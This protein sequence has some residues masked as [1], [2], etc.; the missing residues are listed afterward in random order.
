[1]NIEAVN[2]VDIVV[3]IFG[4]IICLIS[5]FI[6]FRIIGLLKYSLKEKEKLT[7]FKIEDNNEQEI[8]LWTDRKR[9]WGGLIPT[10]TTYTLTTKRLLIRNHFLSFSEEEVWLY[11]IKDISTKISVWQFFFNTGN[12]TVNSFDE[13]MGNFV[14]MNLTNVQIKKEQLTHLA[15]IE[16]VNH[17]YGI[18]ATDMTETLGDA[19]EN[20]VPD[21]YENKA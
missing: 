5:L 12:I 10:F 21:I 18:R 19:D 13:K 14:L 7:G 2:I 3:R 15:E 1:M 16:R 17:R 6:I 11:K 20:G 9:I 4:I 8:T